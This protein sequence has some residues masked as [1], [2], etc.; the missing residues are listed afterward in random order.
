MWTDQ[1]CSLSRLP[2]QGGPASKKER[3][4]EREARRERFV[5]KL[6]YGTFSEEIRTPLSSRD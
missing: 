6:A 4:R 2:F 3:E 5:L 1:D